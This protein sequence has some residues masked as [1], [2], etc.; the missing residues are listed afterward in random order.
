HGVCRLL[1]QAATLAARQEST[2]PDCQTSPGQAPSG[3]K[4]SGLGR[5]E[6][7]RP[8][9]TSHDFHHNHVAKEPFRSASAA[10]AQRPPV[11][12][13]K[14]IHYDWHFQGTEPKIFPEFFGPSQAWI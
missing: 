13:Q 9:R 14:I 4:A 7:P 6:T 2:Q 10:S 5:Q 8:S 12:V 3:R 11:H 1:I